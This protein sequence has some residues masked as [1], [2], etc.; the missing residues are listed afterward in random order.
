MADPALLETF[1]NPHPRRDYLV[2]HH[3]RE[4]TSLCPRT[5]QP[6]FANIKIRYIPGSRCVELKSLKLYLQG[7][8]SRGIFYE[9]VTNVLLETLARV[10]EPRWMS[11]RT[12]WSIRG[13][14]Y[15]VVEART[16]DAAVVQRFLRGTGHDKESDPIGP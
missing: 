9:D 5:G 2:V 6:D 11:V 12:K 3:V 8:R 13:G 4:F 16:G 7:F 10:C 15:T 14:I 1:P